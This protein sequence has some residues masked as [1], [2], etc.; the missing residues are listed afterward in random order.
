M[1]TKSNLDYY[2]PIRLN[3]PDDDDVHAMA[4]RL[5]IDSDEVVGKL[6]RVWAWA[7]Q[8][9][10][11][12][13]L[14]ASERAVD[15]VATAKG[16][17]AAMMEVNWL[18][19]ADD[20]RL[21]IPKWDKWNSKAAKKRAYE[22]DKKRDYRGTEEAESVLGQNEDNCPRTDSG[23]ETGQQSGTH[24]SIE[25]RDKE[26][27]GLKGAAHPEETSSG[28]SAPEGLASA[29][30]CAADA[31]PPARGGDIREVFAHYRTH[32]PK[33]FPSPSSKSKEWRLIA[34]RLAEGYSVD[35]LKAAID[36]NHVSP[37]HCGENDGGRK[38]HALELVMRS[39]DKVAGF[40][41]LLAQ[42][43]TPVVSEKNRRTMRAAES[44]V[45]RRSAEMEAVNGVQ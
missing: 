15:K 3:L 44:Y 29:K 38:Y 19:K 39:G 7:Q 13:S 28:A 5:K 33:A 34:A 41:D 4:D 36:G 16:F 2:M 30:P 1:G 27:T 10:V 25:Y 6:I 24:K 32:H 12:G 21:I 42:V 18:T 20:G 35:D 31:A 45:A 22:R 17:A 8:N 14:R 26:N 11:D 40:I 43:G 23:T 37:F 9:S